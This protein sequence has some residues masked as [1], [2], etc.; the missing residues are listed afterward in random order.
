M[1]KISNINTTNLNSWKT[2]GSSF[3]SYGSN[4]LSGLT[5]RK[6]LNPPNAP[7]VS[8][9]ELKQFA[10]KIGVEIRRDGIKYGMWRYK[11]SFTWFEAG[12]TNYLCMET[13]KEVERQMNEGN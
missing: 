3:S 4:D 12:V 8:I 5:A 10:D 13:L 9:G 6:K 7:K 1:N 2:M 11:V